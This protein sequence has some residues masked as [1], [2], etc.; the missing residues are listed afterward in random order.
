MT[1]VSRGMK[2]RTSVVAVVA[3]AVVGCSDLI[4][5][6]MADL[7]DSALREYALSVERWEDKWDDATRSLDGVEWYDPKLDSLLGEFTNITVPPGRSRQAHE[8]YLRA[9]QLTLL[10]EQHYATLDALE[11]ERY[12]RGELSAAP[13]CEPQVRRSSGVGR[14]FSESCRLRDMAR[15][16]IARAQQTWANLH[17]GFLEFRE[18]NPR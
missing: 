10:A 12:K 6:E 1:E 2:V 5:R 17:I 4:D 8:D 18:E 3:L 16:Q 15:G 13:D 14:L 7:A 9:L 11:M